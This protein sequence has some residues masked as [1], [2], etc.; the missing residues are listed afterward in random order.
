MITLMSGFKQEL[1]K[2]RNSK[3]INQ[4]K[5]N[6]L[7]IQNQ[8]CKL[9]QDLDSK[10]DYINYPEKEISIRD[11]ELDPL[12]LEIFYLKEKLEKIIENS[13]KSR[14]LYQLYREAVSN[15]LGWNR[16]A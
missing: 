11:K 6:L 8:V 14:K 5:G 1:W 7:A 15:F 13:K 12:R 3:R 9:Q 10:E 4:F 16:Q 2:G